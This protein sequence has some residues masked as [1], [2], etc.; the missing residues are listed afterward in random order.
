MGWLGVQCQAGLADEI[1][2]PEGIGLVEVP[3]PT[4]TH[5]VGP[6][7]LPGHMGGGLGLVGF[8][9]R[10]KSPE[11][12][13]GGA[14]TAVARE[15]GGGTAAAQACKKGENV[16]ETEAYCGPTC[17]KDRLT[18]ETSR[19]PCESR[20]ALGRFSPHFPSSKGGWP[21]GGKALDGS[22]KE[23]VM[24]PGN[25]VSKLPLLGQTYHILDSMS[26]VF[27]SCDPDFQP[28]LG[29]KGGHHTPALPCVL[30][31]LIH[32][33]ILPASALPGHPAAS[34]AAA[35][36]IHCLASFW[37]KNCSLVA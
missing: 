18:P 34:Y 11:Q 4:R 20:W 13:V 19:F 25:V 6:R 27:L 35:P 30:P 8:E 29:E 16:A 9:G 3:A 2:G 1:L 36:R 23:G 26:E 28:L 33:P 14:A 37:G 22:R 21:S 32:P 24:T 5:D 12:A 10:R 15:G 7:G 17:G 31:Q